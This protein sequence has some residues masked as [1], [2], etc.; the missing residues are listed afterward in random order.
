MLYEVITL[1]IYNKNPIISYT[2]NSSNLGVVSG[3][4]WT[5]ETVSITDQEADNIF[6][7]SVALSNEIK[8]LTKP[9]SSLLA[10][11]DITNNIVD[12][13]GTFSFTP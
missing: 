10:D 5:S 7:V 13:S 9:D 11:T 1:Y 8:F 4:L 2:A 3:N 12:K 6:G